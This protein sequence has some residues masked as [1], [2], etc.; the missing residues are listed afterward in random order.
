MIA[1]TDDSQDLGINPAATVSDP[2]LQVASGKPAA[3]VTCGG[4]GRRDGEPKLSAEC[5]QPVR[6]LESKSEFVSKSGDLYRCVV[7]ELA[8]PYKKIVKY[9]QNSARLAATARP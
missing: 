2:S 6:D 8:R 4:G 9:L 1:S 7:Q 3:A 5:E